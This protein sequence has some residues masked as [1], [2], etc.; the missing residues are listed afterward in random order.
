MEVRYRHL[1]RHISAAAVI[2]GSLSTAPLEQRPQ[3]T[4]RRSGVS[5]TPMG[6]RSILRPFSPF[7]LLGLCSVIGF[8]DA[9]LRAPSPVTVCS[10]SKIFCLLTDPKTGTHTRIAFVPMALGNPSGP[11]R[12]GTESSFW[13]MTAGM[14]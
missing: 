2:A 1:E 8:A 12:A 9:P 11:C 10:N 4:G 3:R 7:L 14:L 6:A 13:P 5:G